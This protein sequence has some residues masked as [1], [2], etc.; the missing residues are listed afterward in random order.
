MNSMEK[1]V[2]NISDLVY[3]AMTIGDTIERKAEG[4]DPEACYQMGMIHL[5]GIEKP[6]SF[7]MSIAFFSNKSLSS[8]SYA[9]R[10]L[11][12]LNEC[13][14]NYSSAFLNYSKAYDLDNADSKD[15]YINKVITERKNLHDYLNKMCLP[16]SVMNEEISK[17]LDGYK[18]GKIQRVESCSIIASLCN[19]EPT[20]IEAAETALQAED[21]VT[22]R[23]WLDK[24]NVDSSNSLYE[25]I[26]KKVAE[27]MNKINQETAFKVIDLNGNSLVPEFDP[28]NTFDVLKKT[29]DKIASES[30]QQWQEKVKPTIEPII[31]KRKKEERELFLQEQKKE[32][33]RK[34]IRKHLIVFASIY[35]ILIIIAFIAK[36][37]LTWDDFGSS[38]IVAP[39]LY[40][41][42]LIFVWLSGSNEKKKRRK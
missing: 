26:E 40:W 35:L 15:T 5:L 13:D 37:H 33:R 32:E 22:A 42:Y 1:Y 30:Q 29:C 6:V 24:G 25:E 12:F 4:G 23:M 11:G 41:F 2:T 28:N 3:S 17:L 39:S 21:L 14:G 8:Y 36:G 27:S 18:K 19:D 16:K 20:C 10:L 38:L 31:K 34:K 7:R 9:L